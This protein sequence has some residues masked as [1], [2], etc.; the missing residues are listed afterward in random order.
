MSLCLHINVVCNVR[1]CIVR[2]CCNWILCYYS[3]HAPLVVGCGC[4]GDIRLTRLRHLNAE[5]DLL[6]L[7]ILA[8]VRNPMSADNDKLHSLTELGI[9]DDTA[10]HSLEVFTSPLFDRNS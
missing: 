2:C 9:S 5:T 3:A 7:G 1:A 10:K 6:K 4:T 8:G